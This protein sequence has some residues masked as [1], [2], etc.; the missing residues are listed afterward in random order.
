MKRFT[1]I[2]ASILAVILLLG[3]VSV[4]ALPD[5]LNTNRWP[6]PGNIRKQS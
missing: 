6:D 2:I 5:I 3:S 4:Y 1:R